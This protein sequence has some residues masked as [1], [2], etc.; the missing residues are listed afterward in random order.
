MLEQHNLE[1]VN[2]FPY[3]G[4]IISCELK[5]NS[6]IEHR[7]RKLCALGNMIT[8]R[9]GFCNIDTK[10]LLFQTYCYSIYGCSLWTNYT[11]EQL[12]RLKVVH[13]D[14]LRRLTRTPR[15]HSAS[16]LFVNYN[17]MPLK[18][19]I[20]TSM[21]SLMNR[22]MSSNNVNIV[23]VLNSAAIGCSRMWQKWENEAFSNPT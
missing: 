12:R 7:R 17:L 23:N 16:A 13:N 22:L 21:T 9:Y 1:F 18:V 10:I 19:I 15:F 4:H 8:R 11:Q 3:L 5:D 20:R 14:I 6:D 2:E